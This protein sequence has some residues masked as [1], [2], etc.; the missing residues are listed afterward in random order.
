MKGVKFRAYLLNKLSCSYLNK[1]IFRLCVY[2]FFL[3]NIF[4]TS[5]QVASE[6]IKKKKKVVMTRHLFH[7]HTHTHILHTKKNPVWTPPPVQQVFTHWKS[8][9]GT[10]SSRSS[11]NK[12]EK[13]EISTSRRDVGKK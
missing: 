9:E 8:G 3:I 7:T 11:N 13:K 12:K 1:V 2:I 10:R 4:S 6:I 5:D